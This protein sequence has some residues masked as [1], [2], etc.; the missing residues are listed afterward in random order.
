MC[1]LRGLWEGG[2]P[3]KTRWAPGRQLQLRLLGHKMGSL[4]AGPLWPPRVAGRFFGVLRRLGLHLRWLDVWKESCT[5]QGWASV[6]RAVSSGRAE[7]RHERWPSSCPPATCRSTG[8]LGEPPA[9]TGEASSLCLTSVSFCRPEV[10]ARAVLGLGQ[11]GLSWDRRR[12]AQATHVWLGSLPH[13]PDPSCT[14]QEAYHGWTRFLSALPGTQ[15]HHGT[16]T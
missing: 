5:P 6:G 10:N 2:E 8:T 4:W 9:D 7:R 1:S 13:R 15:G 14:G 11:R 12:P 16:A 3:Q